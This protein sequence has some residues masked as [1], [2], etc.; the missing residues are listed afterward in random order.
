MRSGVVVLLG[1]LTLLIGCTKDDEKGF[2]IFSYAFDFSE[3]S[4]GWQGDFAGYAT[5]DSLANQL[6]FAYVNLPA[7]L[8]A[9][10]S[11]MLS[12]YNPNGDLLMYLKKQLTELKPNTNYTIAFDIEFATNAPSDYISIGS[13]PGESVYLKAGASTEEPFKIVES[14]MYYIN[15]DK[16]AYNNANGINM[17]VVGD[18]AASSGG[19]D[20]Q[21]EKRT[22]SLS[23]N[24]SSD[25]EG[26]L[27]III[28]TDSSYRGLT[29]IYYTQIKVVLSI[30]D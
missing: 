3:E 8:G 18:I 17:M 6:E 23:F 22:S 10:K 15:I 13:A 7:S 11:L 16:G 12:G 9:A 28:G 2:Y 26:K 14:D 27:W 30:I 1:F 5:E 20:Y 19:A 24:A 25:S 21:I 29:T 4:H